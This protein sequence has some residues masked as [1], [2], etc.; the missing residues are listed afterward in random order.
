MLHFDKASV[1]TARDTIDFMRRNRMKRARHPP[2]SPDLAR[3]DFYLFG[4]VKT[5]LQGAIFADENELLAGSTDV[6]TGIPREEIEAVFDEWLLRLDVC[7]QRQGDDV[8]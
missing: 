5:A 8:E 3:S 2:F 1:H 7:I 6:L 4:K